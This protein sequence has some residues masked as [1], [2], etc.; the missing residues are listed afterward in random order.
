MDKQNSRG[1]K[2]HSC[3]TKAALQ[4]A[5]TLKAHIQNQVFELTAA[6]KKVEHE[7]CMQIDQQCRAKLQGLEY[8]CEEDKC[9]PG[10][11]NLKTEFDDNDGFPQKSKL[12]WD[13]KVSKRLF[14]N[15]G[16]RRTYDFSKIMARVSE[17]L[18]DPSV[19]EQVESGKNVNHDLDSEDCFEFVDS[20]ECL[21]EELHSE[22]RNVLK[23]RGQ[24]LPVDNS[25]E[26]LERASCSSV[27]SFDVIPNECCMNDSVCL[28]AQALPPIARLPNLPEINSPKGGHT[29]FY[30]PNLQRKEKKGLFS[31]ILKRSPSRNTSSADMLPSKVEGTEQKMSI[32][33]S[34]TTV[35]G[36]DIE[37]ISSSEDITQQEMPMDATD[38]A[39]SQ[40]EN[41]PANALQDS[42]KP[43]LQ[44]QDL[45]AWVHPN[46]KS[47]ANNY[48]DWVFR[49]AAPSDPLA[50]LP[51]SSA[52]SSEAVGAF[53]RQLQ[54]F[55]A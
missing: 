18:K 22:I 53:F 23:N 39:V 3:N 10:C 41:N 44:K 29:T 15:Y 48:E 17:A 37:V 35:D 11:Q 14:Q 9:A 38:S 1:C 49:V 43:Y 7:L 20:V 12:D 2:E 52:C 19:M 31:R 13:F 24:N 26:A 8:L 25:E 6:L 27:D 28:H 16:Q 50:E 42:F 33:V 54:A 21:K 40:G 5:T 55:V 46:S 47:K 30:L 32:S 34:T 36:D 4:Y 51:S 45:K